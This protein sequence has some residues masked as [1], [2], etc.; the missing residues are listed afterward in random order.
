MDKCDH[1]DVVAFHKVFDCWVNNFHGDNSK[2]SEKCLAWTDFYA[3]YVFMA[4][5]RSKLGPR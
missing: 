2:E 1:P 3:N 4:C 5:K